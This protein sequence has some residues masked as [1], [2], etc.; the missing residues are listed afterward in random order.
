VSL[1]GLEI[2]VKRFRDVRSLVLDLTFGNGLFY[3][4]STAYISALANELTMDVRISYR[5]F[6]QLILSFW[7]LFSMG[8]IGAYAGGDVRFRKLALGLG[9]MASGFLATGFFL[10]N[11]VFS[12]AVFMLSAITVVAMLLGRRLAGLSKASTPRR[13]LVLGTGLESHQL[14]DRLRQWPQFY[15][16]VGVM[17]ESSEV[18]FDTSVSDFSGLPVADLSSLEQTTHALEIDALVLPGIRAVELLPLLPRKLPSGL[19]VQIEVPTE[20]GPPLLG[21]VTLDRNTIAELK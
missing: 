7:I 1:A 17:A 12:R 14:A 2:L 18:G 11:I 10:K 13:L 16:V 21:D 19:A 15:R 5:W 8:M 6:W 9:G 4:I 20:S 3:L